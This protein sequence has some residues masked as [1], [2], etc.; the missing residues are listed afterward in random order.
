[1]VRDCI[2]ILEYLELPKLYRAIDGKHVVITAPANSGSEFFNYK[3]YSIV[4]MALVD[5]NYNF[6]VVDI[7]AYGRWRYI[8]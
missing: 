2:F 8:C 6:I 4:L 1:M 5:A 7:G 3:K